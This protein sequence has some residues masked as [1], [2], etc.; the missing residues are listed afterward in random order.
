MGQR[1]SAAV[2]L[3]VFEAGEAGGLPADDLSTV[4]PG[5]ARR[6]VSEASAALA[7]NPLFV[8]A[9]AMFEHRDFEGV[10]RPPRIL[11]RFAPPP[12]RRDHNRL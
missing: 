1:V 10:L 12:E 5:G 11:R 3:T 6:G 7:S 4:V 8:P 9:D 2:A